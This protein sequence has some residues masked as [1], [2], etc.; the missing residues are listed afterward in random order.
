[1]EVFKFSFDLAKATFVAAV[2]TITFR[3]PL[4]TLRIR[5]TTP[6]GANINNNIRVEHKHYCGTLCLSMYVGRNIKYLSV[7]KAHLQERIQDTQYTIKLRSCTL[8]INEIY[9]VV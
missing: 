4:K 3:W 5:Y 7:K 2:R 6:Y 9:S 8:Y 1:M